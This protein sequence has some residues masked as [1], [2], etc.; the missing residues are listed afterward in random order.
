MSGKIV[1]ICG[2]KDA[3]SASVAIKRGANLLGVI[4]V[5]NR[6][7]TVEDDKAR[8][9]SNLCRQQRKRLNRRF[10][11]SKELINYARTLS[12]T[13]ALWFEDCSK[14]II[15]NGPFLVGVFRNQPLDDVISICKRLDIDIVQLHGS[16]NLEEYVPALELPVIARFTPGR[17]DLSKA[18][19]THKHLLPLLDSE[20]GGQG[21]MIDWAEAAEFNRDLDGQFILAGGLTPENVDRALLVSGCLGVDVSGGVETDGSK[22]HEKIERFLR[23]ARKEVL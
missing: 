20:A 10:Q 19:Q 4:L 14:L 7:R 18:V 3:E 2:L 23:N 8:E 16:E 12:S 21:K 15:E 6:K 22:D 17:S 13:G 5:P 9:I 1:K 11:T